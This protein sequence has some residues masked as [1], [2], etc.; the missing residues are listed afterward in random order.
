[1]NAWDADVT[2]PNHRA[3]QRGL[4]KRVMQRKDRWVG[5]GSLLPRDQRD[6]VLKGSHWK[7]HTSCQCPHSGPQSEGTAECQACTVGPPCKASF[8]R[9]PQQQLQCF[10]V[11]L[12][13][14]S[15]EAP[16]WSLR[17]AN[18]LPSTLQRIPILFKISSFLQSGD[19]ITRTPL[20]YLSM[21]YIPFPY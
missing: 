20:H 13:S 8:H 19:H 5:L 16:C 21:V 4:G 12:L 11:C 2:L 17:K 6:M 18:S 15:Y 9:C 7:S 3:S 10:L 1:M 14:V